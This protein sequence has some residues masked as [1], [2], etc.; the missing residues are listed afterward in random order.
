VWIVLATYAQLQC[1]IDRIGI[2]P[3]KW[4]VGYVMAGELDPEHSA[5]EECG[6]ILNSLALKLCKRR[7]RHY[8]SG[9]C[10]QELGQPV[11]SMLRP[12]GQSFCSAWIC[13]RLPEGRVGR[14]LL[15]IVARDL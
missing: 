13:Q 10:L 11:L 14:R 3:L 15:Q 2:S 6:Q 1:G 12:Y 7:D 9:N 5:V 4:I 8:S